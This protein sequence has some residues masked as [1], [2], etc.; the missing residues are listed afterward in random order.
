[1]EDSDGLQMR[2]EMQKE[3]IDEEDRDSPISPALWIRAIVLGRPN[4]PVPKVS[5]TTL[6][7]LQRT[8]ASESVIV[9]PSERS[10]RT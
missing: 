8:S 5:T 6:S 2:L 7:V 4:V 1:M 9:C 3:T 10:Y